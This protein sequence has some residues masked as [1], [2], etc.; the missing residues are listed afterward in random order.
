[1]GAG[2]RMESNEWE[3]KF[4]DFQTGEMHK[5]GVGIGGYWASEK[6]SWQEGVG[7][8]L[9]SLRVKKE[10][11]LDVRGLVSFLRREVR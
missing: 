5:T 11:R 1:M 4:E 2:F 9:G 8:N 7:G 3:R 6:A 10:P